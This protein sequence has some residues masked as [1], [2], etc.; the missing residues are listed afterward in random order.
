MQQVTCPGCGA[1]V[2]FK[3][4]ASVLAVCGYCKTTLLK[5]A[6]SVKNLG[7]MSE[8]LEDYSPLQIG[9]SGRQGGRGFTVI[10]RIQLQYSAGFWNEW[11]VMFDDGGGGWLSDASGQYALTV[12]KQT[13]AALPLFD[14]LVP[15]RTLRVSSQL[16]TISDVRT[17][18][19]TAGQGELPF[20]VGPGWEARVADFRARDRFMTLDY[21]DA[22]AT[23]VY[24][25]E[26]VEL[27][28]LSAQL[29]RDTTQISDAAGRFRGKIAALNCPACG[30][31]L[32][33]VTGITVQS[34]CPS[35]HAQ[36]DTAG[37]V[38]VVLAAGAAVEAVHFTL[39]LGASMSLD[40]QSYT[41]IGALRRTEGD[42]SSVWSEYLVY[43][44]GKEFIWLVETDAGWQ[45]AQVMNR[46]PDWDGAQIAGFQDRQF[47][48]QTSYDAVVVFAVGS[49]NWR[50]AVGDRTRIMEFS[51]HDTR[52][53]AE[54]TREEMT[55]TRSVPVPLDQVRAWFGREVHAERSPQ[56][57]YRA[58]ARK[59][60]VALVLINVVPL[61]AAPST[62]IL[63]S[64][65]AALGIYLPA[66]YLDRLDAE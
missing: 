31:A 19:C 61:F 23:R 42:G 37:S 3:S 20:K 59:M 55:W 44:P 56:P 26:A 16:Y 51:N 46:W 15:G 13:S 10:G 1:P 48:R 18:R 25:G 45:R 58:T 21:S 62:T 47:A 40:G 66:Y 52:L 63:Y 53:A 29:L 65:L 2:E 41:V 38:A 64:L 5:D 24:V 14:K 43:A 49:F 8:V 57:T 4:T 6:D 12:E 34:L 22:A 30:S 28:S 9:S 32:K 11:Y 35:C 54:V 27:A 60:L 36:I 33:A 7:K 50:V 39:E 17:A